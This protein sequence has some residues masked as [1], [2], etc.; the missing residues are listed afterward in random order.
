MMSDQELMRQS[1]AIMTQ[2]RFLVGGSC[3]T[4][5]QSLS[6]AD[7]IAAGEMVQ[8]LRQLLDEY[9]AMIVARMKD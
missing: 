8:K 3:L 1:G 4:T 9:D 2:L 6:P 5:G 7:V